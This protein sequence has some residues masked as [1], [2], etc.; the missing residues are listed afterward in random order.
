MIKCDKGHVYVDANLDQMLA[1]FSTLAGAIREKLVEVNGEKE[2]RSLL[3]VAYEDSKKTPNQLIEDILVMMCK[4]IIER[5][6]K[7]NG[8]NEEN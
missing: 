8:R 2:G 1:E 4:R 6:E 7:E 3:D 5:K